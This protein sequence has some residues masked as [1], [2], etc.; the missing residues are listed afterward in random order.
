MPYIH[1]HNS[2]FFDL[3]FFVGDIFIRHKFVISFFYFDIFYYF[4]SIT[5]FYTFDYTPITTL[6]LYGLVFLYKGMHYF[7]N[8]ALF[9]T[10]Y[11]ICRANSPN[12][13]VLHHFCWKGTLLSHQYRHYLCMIIIYFLQFY[14]SVVA[15]VA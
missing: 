7:C 9:T 11:I 12:R 10:Y 8:I 14:L 2:C 5:T 15:M 13:V 6:F 3:P 1:A 4:F